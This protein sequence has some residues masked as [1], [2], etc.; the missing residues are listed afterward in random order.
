MATVIISISFLF[1][2]SS[3]LF[4]ILFFVIFRNSYFV[5]CYQLP[6]FLMADKANKL[7]GVYVFSHFVAVSFFKYLN[8][9]VYLTCHS[10]AEFL[11]LQAEIEYAAKTHLFA[12]LLVL[13]SSL[14]LFLFSNRY[15]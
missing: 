15:I 7:L 5:K 14:Y 12:F 13:F 4:S 11:R 1:T 2:S 6:R 3:W 10:Q 8:L 9:R